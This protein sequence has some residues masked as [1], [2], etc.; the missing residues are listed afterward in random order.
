M[1]G[2]STGGVLTWVKL[3]HNLRPKNN[4]RGEAPKNLNLAVI[5]PSLSAQTRDQGAPISVSKPYI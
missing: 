1:I 5:N 4:S 3:G 2:V